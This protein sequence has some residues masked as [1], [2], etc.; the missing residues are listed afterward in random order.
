M[1]MSADGRGKII[2]DMVA[3]EG[4]SEEEAIA[5]HY[6]TQ[7]DRTPMGRVG[8]PSEAASLIAFLASKEAD[9]ITGEAISVNGGGGIG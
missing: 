3:K 6:K 4:I 2:L 1:S 7:A 8:E 5:R 9:Y